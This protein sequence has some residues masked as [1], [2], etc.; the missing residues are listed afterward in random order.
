MQKEFY[1]CSV[2]CL[3]DV[4]Q[5]FVSVNSILMSMGVVGALGASRHP[6]WD[7]SRNLK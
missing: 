4:D 5:S 7:Q 1:V 3:F 6:A 2:N